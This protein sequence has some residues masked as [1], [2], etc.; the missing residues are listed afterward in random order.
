MLYLGQHAKS[1]HVM[2]KPWWKNNDVHIISN[3]RGP[4][5]SL[6]EDSFIPTMHRNLSIVATHGQKN[7]HKK[8]KSFLTIHRRF[9][10]AILGGLATPNLRCMGQPKW[11]VYM[12]ILATKLLQRT[13]C[14]K[15]LAH[16]TSFLPM[17]PCTSVCR[18]S[19]HLRY[20]S[21]AIR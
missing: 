2:Q 12:H 17:Y 8:R 19:Q 11:L 14:N 4:L 16:G 5:L 3:V 1:H 6:G 21:R 9:L 18:P 20:T 15:W 10:V 7:E 13:S